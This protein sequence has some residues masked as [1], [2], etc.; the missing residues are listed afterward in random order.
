M[1]GTH[2]V[3]AGEHM[4]IVST[5]RDHDALCIYP[6]KEPKMYKC[7]TAIG[8]VVLLSMGAARAQNPS[9]DSVAA[10]RSL[11]TTLRLTDQYRVLLP[12]ILFS[13]RPTLTQDRPE[14]ERDF[15]AMVPTVLGTYGTYYNTM[16]D[17]AA[18]LYAKNFSTD[19]LRA[20]ETFYRSPAGQKYL[21]K[22]RELARMSQQIGEEISRK[23]VDDLK[24]RMTQL[25]R[26]K[27]HKL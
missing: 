2:R 13:L 9:P 12:G 4:R 6:F 3:P 10:A 18:A 24:A 11:V 15:D 7:L 26:E 25:L 8:I 1:F 21:E 20:I 22:S 14:I 16:I 5:K 17:G 19:E 27:G 23:A